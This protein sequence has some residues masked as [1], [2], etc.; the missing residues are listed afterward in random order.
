MDNRF[1]RIHEID[2]EKNSVHMYLY[3]KESR[4]WVK[5]VSCL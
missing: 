5:M 2:M 1:P 4:Q 3:D